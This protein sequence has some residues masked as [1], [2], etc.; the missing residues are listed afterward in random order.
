MITFA[1][2]VFCS[3]LIL[4]HLIATHV[5]NNG[6]LFQKNDK[7]KAVTTLLGKRFKKH[8][9]FSAEIPIS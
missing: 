6:D 7:R 2:F 9:L 3:I 1:T 5:E 4:H 8:E